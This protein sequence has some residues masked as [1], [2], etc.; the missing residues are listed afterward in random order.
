M[1]YGVVVCLMA[2]SLRG[3]GQDS[4][5]TSKYRV[6]NISMLT[7]PKG[8]YA[9]IETKGKPEVIKDEQGRNRR[10]KNTT[11]I[12]NYMDE[13]GWELVSASTADKNGWEF[14]CVFRR[15]EG[16]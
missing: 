2:L 4:T 7:I 10:F 16:K 15:K 6:V 11:E 13:Q 9:G 1:G 5:S 14:Y 12:Y 8:I 3:S